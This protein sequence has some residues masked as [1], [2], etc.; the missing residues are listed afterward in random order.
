MSQYN[1]TGCIHSS[2]SLKSVTQ[3]FITSECAIIKTQNFLF[4]AICGII[5]KQKYFYAFAVGMQVNIVF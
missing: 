1:P 4:Q 2:Y 3:G 5:N